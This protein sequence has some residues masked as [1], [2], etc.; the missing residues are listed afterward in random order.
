MVLEI[1]AAC[2]RRFASDGS[3]NDVVS[4][5]PLRF[6]A[7]V[8]TSVKSHRPTLRTLCDGL[9]LLGGIRWCAPPPTRTGLSSAWRVSPSKTVGHGGRPS[10]LAR[11]KPLYPQQKVMV[12]RAQGPQPFSNMTSP[13]QLTL[14]NVF[15]SMAGGTYGRR[16]QL[17]LARSSLFSSWCR[18]QIS[19]DTIAIKRRSCWCHASGRFGKAVGFGWTV[20]AGVRHASA[21]C[22]SA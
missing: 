1:N 13:R 10:A 9:G 17:C 14:S 20:I 3:S 4:W 12:L 15:D 16:L 11:R 7:L 19:F 22:R 21:P 18:L 6:T 5:H 8:V 2:R